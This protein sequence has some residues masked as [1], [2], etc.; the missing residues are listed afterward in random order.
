MVLNETAKLLGISLRETEDELVRDML[1]STATILSAVNGVNGD[2]PTEIADEDVQIVIRRLLNNDAKSLMHNIEGMDKF[3]TAPVRNS[4]FALAHSDLSS[5][6]DNLADF[7]HVSQYPSQANLL[8]SEW[9][10]SKNLRFLL[11]SQGSKVLSSSG[12]GNDLYNVFCIGLEALA[13]VDQDGYSAQFIY[14]PP[15]YDGPL[16]QNVSLGYK[17]AQAVRILNDAWI[18]NLQCSLGL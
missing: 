2:N 8:E 4:F 7:T 18:V 16:A 11:S 15:I 5:D 1:A 14:R 13:C 10:A 12:N 3:G 9:G 17:F 6:L